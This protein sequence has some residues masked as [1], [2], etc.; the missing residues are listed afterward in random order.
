MKKRL[1]LG[2]LMAILITATGLSG[3]ALVS[4][5]SAHS[6]HA[7]KITRTDKH[8]RATAKLNQA[9]R[10]GAITSAQKTAFEAEVKS[11]KSERAKDITQSSTRIERQAERAKL[12]GEL[13]AWASSNN[14]PL[15]KIFPKLAA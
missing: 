1:L 5:D 10:D 13:L 3:M 14:F 11:L 6:V 12:K 8:I 9:I 2:G 4:A 7:H 15:A